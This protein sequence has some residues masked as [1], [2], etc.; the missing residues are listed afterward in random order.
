MTIIVAVKFSNGVVVATDSRS[1]Y[2][3]AQYVRDTERKIDTL[4][5]KVAVTSSGIRA[6]SNRIFKEL[7]SYVEANENLTFDEIVSECEDLMRNFYKRYSG[8]LKEELEDGWSFEL[9][10]SE[11]MVIIES[12][13]VADEEESYLCDGSGTPYAEYILRQ[14][15]KPD[16][17]EQ[18]CKELACYVVL[19]TSLIDPNVGGP[20]NLCVLKEIGLKHLTRPE[21][22][23]IV[24]NIKETPIEQQIKIQSLVEE[25]VEERR[26]I[27]DLFKN[28]FKTALFKQD[29]YAISQIQKTCKNENDF[30]NRISAL[31]VLI[32]RTESLDVDDRLGEKNKASINRLQVFADKNMPKLNPEC[33]KNLREIYTLRSHK[34]PIHEDDPRLMQ[35][36]LQWEY[37]IPPN[38]GNL[39]EKALTKYRDSL[40]MLKAAV[41]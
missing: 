34:M 11:R 37:K 33:I 10:S 3:E 25:I 4:N 27:N 38:W 41:Q 1:I 9:F 7:R 30:T 35:I 20:V 17:T 13:G 19:Q 8:R 29:E 31:A 32:D 16:L 22:D 6:A 40:K 15:Y 26:W 23:E 39:W 28:K 24:E 36:L 21:I 2:G 14:R 5:D 18:E 12:D